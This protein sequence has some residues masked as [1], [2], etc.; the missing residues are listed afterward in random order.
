MEVFELAE[1]L[2]QRYRDYLKASFYFRDPALRKEFESALNKDFITKGPYLQINSVFKTGKSLAEIYKL[3]F[4]E[5]MED[6]VRQALQAD[7]PLYL[8]QEK[9]IQKALEGKN[10]LVSTGTG[11]G[12]TESFLFPII[13]HLYRQFKTNG[14]KPGVNALILYPMNALAND[15]RDRI[16]LVPRK[17]QD[18]GGI[19]HEL[20]KLGSDFY[21]TLGQYTGETPE[22][23]NDT[24]RVGDRDLSRVARGE[25]MTREQIRKTPPNILITNY[26]MLEY[27]LLRPNDS[28]L[29]DKGCAATWTFLVL[30]EV[31]QY[32]GT[33]GMEMAMLIRR[34]KNR[35]LSEGGNNQFR[36]IAT[37]ASLTN[38]G[39]GLE[40]V[41]EFASNLFGEPFYPDNI[42][43]GEKESYDFKITKELSLNNYRDLLSLDSKEIEIGSALLADMRTK[44]FSEL[45]SRAT[46]LEDIA[47]NLF[48]EIL[49]TIEKKEALQC[50]FKL[51]F[52]AKHPETKRNLFVGKFHHF[53]RSLQGA[54][55]RL[56]E[57]RSIALEK[58]SIDLAA[59]ELALCSECGQEY[60]VGAIRNGILKE[61]I[62]EQTSLN[63]CVNYYRVLTEIPEN[64]SS[65]EQL[66]KLCRKCAAVCKFEEQ[67]QCEHDFF[68][69]LQG[70]A[71]GEDKDDTLPACTNCNFKSQDPVKEI[72]HGTDGPHAVIAST[73]FKKL[74]K[75]KNKLLAFSDGR[76]E[77]AF[78]AWYLDSSQKKI[79]NRR[80]FLISF[81]SVL[82]DAEGQP[83]I[84]SL[85]KK[86]SADLRNAEAKSLKGPEEFK[87]DAS[88]IVLNELASNETRL[89]LEGV[90]LITWKIKHADKISIPERLQQSPWG[91]TKEQCA[92]LVGILLDTLRDDRAVNLKASDW[93]ELRI[94]GGGTGIII[95]APKGNK[96][97]RSWDGLKGRRANIL[98]RIC[99]QPDMLSKEDIERTL[100]EIF[101]SVRDHDDDF[102]EDDK[103]FVSKNDSF[104]LNW[105][106]FFAVEP[107]V[108]DLRQCSICNR[109]S[110][111]KALNICTRF[112]CLGKLTELNREQFDQNHYRKL[113]TETESS[114]LIVEEHSAQL[115]NSKARAFQRD[116]KNGK[117]NVL[118]CS[119]TFELGVDLGDLDAV[120]LRNVPPE[121]FNYDQRVGRAGR[122]IGNPGFAVTYCK[123]SPHDLYHFFDPLKMITGSIKPPAISLTNEKIIYRHLTA[124]VLSEFF[125][126]NA[127]RF[128]K[129]SNFVQDWKA[130]RAWSDVQLFYTNNRHEL[131]NSFERILKLKFD[132]SPGSKAFFESF[133]ANENKFNSLLDENCTLANAEAE[134]ASDYLTVHDFEKN[135]SEKGNYKD[136]DWAKRRRET[137]EGESVL[138]FL[139]RKAV[140]PKYGF[141]V[142]VVELDTHKLKS[143]STV[144]L[145]R[146]LKVALSE[147]APSNE[148]IANKK[149]WTSHGIK[150]VAGKEWPSKRFIRCR[151]HN[152]FYSWDETEKVPELMCK[153]CSGITGGVYLIPQFG[154]TTKRDSAKEPTKRI[155]KM[156]SSQPYSL[157]SGLDAAKIWWPQNKPIVTITRAQPERMAVL[158]EGKDKS[159]FSICTTCGYGESFSDKNKPTK[160]HVDFLGKK[161]SG[162]LKRTNLGHEFVTDVLHMNFHLSLPGADNQLSLA[163]SVATA[164]LEG[165]SEQLEVPAE[166]INSTVGY[167]SDNFKMP[168]LVFY[169][170]VPGGAG[171]V[172]KMEDFSELCEILKKAKNRVSG[173][174]GCTEGESCYGC[175]RNY[176]NQFIHEYLDRSLASEYIEKALQG[177][178]SDLS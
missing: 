158:C 14:H 94:K 61:A 163:Y 160:E 90:G 117:I 120:F 154:F 28:P 176:R 1:E 143:T 114:N 21:F 162:N 150:K 18:E 106:R 138:A 174:C 45:L 39:D 56:D 149:L 86:I 40:K 2:G 66:Y 24:T 164:I 65:D 5:S 99:A 167:I 16:A 84:D 46:T 122:R 17:T 77:A 48:P 113:Y 140:I 105:R 112:N 152:Y 78:F 97:S 64:L 165:T 148:L 159:G 54:Y 53:I 104:Q 27:L 4:G 121:S 166:D 141:P 135:C 36:C 32:K 30:D 127:D 26:S 101:E 25:L 50:Y 20:E 92:E 95:G 103:I 151:E 6:S 139:S 79:E 55:L 81:K 3:N 74:P 9:A 70:L 115:A 72:V 88:N 76:Q 108:L 63:F 171:L 73:I 42:I 83:S 169:D 37:S 85:I 178:L 47:E 15:Q 116:F 110:S 7:R 41:A 146:D 111:L 100:R 23:K 34:L 22:D 91:L 62:R 109:I 170:N 60:I 38:D 128:S 129:L 71:P 44:R 49:E 96:Y 118:S 156:F 126:K 172:S 69:L 35:I 134:A 175:L 107:G 89:S 93:D 31:H 58:S 75:G 123:R 161:C 11:S 173:L 177:L 102:D 33:K 59:H 87:K 119:T 147:F 157:Q 136:A 82:E 137:I 57:P 145:T 144:D 52:K 68:C 133:F 130:P 19:L 132:E 124:V 29:F 155:S 8:H 13:T 131:L 67:L 80:K 98:R 142:D 10:V 43:T 12:K 125:R 51:V 153:D 168:T